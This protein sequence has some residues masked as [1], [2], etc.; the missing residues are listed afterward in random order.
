ML[1]ASCAALLNVRAMRAKTSVMAAGLVAIAMG[2]GGSMTRAQR[3]EA[4]KSSV[5]HLRAGRFDEAEAGATSAIGKDDRNSEARA[6]RA[7]VA[8]LRTTRRFY[9][10]AFFHGRVNTKLDPK[11][12]RELFERTEKDLASIDEDLA[13][14]AKDDSFALELCLACWTID[15]NRDGDQGAADDALFEIERDADGK[16]IPKDDPRRK[17]TFRFDVGDVHWARA[18]IAYQRAILDIA[19]AYRFDDIA[20]APHSDARLVIRLADASRLKS[21][22]ARILEGLEHSARERDAYLAEKDDD[23]EWVPNPHQKN[24][25]LPLP[26]D[27]ALY[28]TWKD[29]LRDVRS[30]IES[31]EGID[32]GE[33]TRLAHEKHALHGYLDLGRLL[34]DP[35]DIDIDFENVK[36]AKNDPDK[37]MQLVFGNAYV[38]KMKPS[39]LIKR[40]VRM[41]HEIDR[42]DDTFGRKLRYLFWLN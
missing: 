26:V 39:P 23:R 32:V 41:S 4:A 15:W 28:E 21:A 18:M 37:A 16:P 8:Y 25:P 1:I 6:V 13:V 2:C 31:D 22:R 17:P 30:L 27:E 36:K 42:G 10:A 7:L 33:L 38:A 19:L 11:R 14:A 12:A 35:R 24:H 40:L 9:E 29:V 3:H 5:E 20:N 34:D